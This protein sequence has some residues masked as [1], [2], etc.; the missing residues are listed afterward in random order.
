MEFEDGTFDVVI[1]KCVLDAVLCAEDAT[2]KAL[3]VIREV[4]R[5]LKMGGKYLMFS[6][7][8]PK[9]RVF[10]FRNRLVKMAVRTTGVS[11][12][13]AFVGRLRKEEGEKGRFEVEGGG[14]REQS[15]GS[16]MT[17]NKEVKVEHYFYVCTKETETKMAEQK[18]KKVAV[19]NEDDEFSNKE[20][21]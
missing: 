18:E 4:N 13:E 16:R 5:V 6:H 2:R 7:S 17:V 19:V 8:Q 20:E 12:G 10:L 15:R 11:V 3:R 1:D 14:M 9:N 21:E